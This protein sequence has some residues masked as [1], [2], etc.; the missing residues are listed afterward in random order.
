LLERFREK[1]L[2]VKV[3]TEAAAR[4]LLGS[5]L[6]YASMDGILSSNNV[7]RAPTPER[8]RSIADLFVHAINLWIKRSRR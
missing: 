5:L 6:T 7:P 1:G 4:M 8:V 3:D 2:A